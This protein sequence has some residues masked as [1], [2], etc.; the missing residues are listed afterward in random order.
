MS[1]TEPIRE[2]EQLREL[3]AYWYDRKNYRNYLLIVLGVCTALRPC[4][5][6][7]LKWIDVYD[8]RREGF[9]SHVQVTEQKTG[10]QI[11]IALNKDALAALQ[12]YFP[13]RRGGFIFAN[14]RP[15]AAPLSRSQAWRI[16]K[17][18]ARAI[19]ASERI[20]L[21]S[22]RKTLG[23]HAAKAGVFPVLLMEL[24]NH[25]SFDITRRYI[26]IDQEDRDGVYLGLNLFE[27]GSS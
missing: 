12:T 21:Y 24:Y 17:T 27:L 11:K 4:D 19:G 25:S 6:L 5:L 8:E 13:H 14:N 20:S 7:L 1:A 3:A 2:L 22:L 23:Y 18:A 16:V 26:C 15:E 9:R 10:K